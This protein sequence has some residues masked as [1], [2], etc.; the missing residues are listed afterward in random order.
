[1]SQNTICTTQSSGLNLDSALFFTFFPS[2]V[3]HTAKFLHTVTKQQQQQ[4]ETRCGSASTCGSRPHCA[5]VAA[6][7][8]T[9]EQPKQSRTN[10][11]SCPLLKTS[12]SLLS[13]S[14]A[15]GPTQ[16]SQSRRVGSLVRSD[17]PNRDYT[18][19]IY[20]VFFFASSG[21]NP[22]QE[23]SICSIGSGFKT[24]NKKKGT[25]KFEVRPLRTQQ[26][27]FSGRQKMWSSLVFPGC[28]A[29]ILEPSRL[30]LHQSETAWHLPHQPIG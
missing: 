16:S 4:R 28:L 30:H 7:A 27:T 8:V 2:D 25:M 17:P 1:M 15:L 29:G 23:A 9:V 26:H 24:N 13:C 22:H 21:F 14:L 6:A 5:V 19:K 11:K 10:P 12:L 3:K 20:R 18:I